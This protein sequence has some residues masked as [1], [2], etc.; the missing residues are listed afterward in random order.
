M[1]KHQQAV[2]DSDLKSE[3]N[4]HCIETAVAAV[5]RAR[6]FRVNEINHLVEKYLEIL[7]PELRTK[8]LNSF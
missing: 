2:A 8:K 6:D 7:P 5:M 1:T 3:L 4:K